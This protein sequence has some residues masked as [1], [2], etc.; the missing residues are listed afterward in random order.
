MLQRVAESY[1]KRFMYSSEYELF[2]H[3][4]FFS[5]VF[6]KR[7]KYTQCGVV[8]YSVLQL[9]ISASSVS[10]EIYSNVTYIYS[11]L[12]HVAACCSVF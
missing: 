4:L 12:Q 9:S 1:L 8:C 2:P 11:M 7:D 10:A 3:I 5:V 6:L